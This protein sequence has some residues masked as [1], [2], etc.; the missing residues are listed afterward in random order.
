MV[1][2]SLSLLVNAFPSEM[3]TL[4]MFA[5]RTLGLLDTGRDALVR[6]APNRGTTDVEARSMKIE[7]VHFNHDTSSASADAL[8]IRKNAA[9]GPIVAPEWKDGQIPQPAAY[10]SAAI[11]N[12]VS[13]KARFSGGP[14]NGSR[15]IRAIDACL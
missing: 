14:L 3:V 6:L 4:S 15:E 7:E 11:G 9:G 8:S 12:Q 13:I 1:S 5:R 10:A 2:L